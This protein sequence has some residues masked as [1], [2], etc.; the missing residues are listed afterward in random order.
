MASDP[1][2]AL[3]AIYAINQLIDSKDKEKNTIDIEYEEVKPKQ[4]E[5]NNEKRSN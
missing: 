5:E 4:L 1:Y 3:Y 2:Y